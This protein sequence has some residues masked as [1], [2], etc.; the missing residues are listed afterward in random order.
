MST[1]SQAIYYANREDYRNM[2]DDLLKEILDTSDE[3]KTEYRRSK[4]PA[5]DLEIKRL[6]KIDEICIEELSKRASEDPKGK[7]KEVEKNLEDPKGK[8]K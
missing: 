6:T 4:V 5:A 3:M 7:G 8:G 2:S 1:A